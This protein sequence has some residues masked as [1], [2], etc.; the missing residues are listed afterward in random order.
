[1][2]EFGLEPLQHEQR[3]V[4]PTYLAQA[5]GQ[6]V[7]TGYEASLR[8]TNEVVTV[9]W[10][11]DVAKDSNSSHWLPIWPTLIPSPISGSRTE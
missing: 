2:A 10:R 9:P 6:R 8:S 3:P 4:D 7:L 5:P 11:I 1:M